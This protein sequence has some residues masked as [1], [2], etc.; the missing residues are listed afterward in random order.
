MPASNPNHHLWRNGRL[1]WVAFTVIHDGWR[2][3]RVRRSLRTTD[4]EEARR[5]RDDLFRQYAT[6][7]SAE[8]AALRA[9]PVQRDETTPFHAEPSFDARCSFGM[10][11]ERSHV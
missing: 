2:Q 7:P 4:L 5:R 10:S 1:W 9:A 11:A 6:L 8:V 3:E